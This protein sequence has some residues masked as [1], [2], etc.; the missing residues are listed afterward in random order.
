MAATSRPPLYPRVWVGPYQPNNP[1]PRN[2]LVLQ[3]F[4]NVQNANDFT[5]PP[6]L[7]IDRYIQNGLPIPFLDLRDYKYTTLEPNKN[8]YNPRKY[9]DPFTQRTY[10]PVRKTR[11][12]PMNGSVC[13]YNPV[14]AVQMP[15]TGTND[16]MFYST[17]G[18]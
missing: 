3:D 15:A 10:F 4:A 11:K 2:E 8:V 7:G 16:V 18:L 5:Q 13:A 12:P 14:D 17:V 1:G 9:P 6:V